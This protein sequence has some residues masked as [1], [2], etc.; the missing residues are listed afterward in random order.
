V[1]KSLLLLLDFTLVQLVMI[2]Y[3]WM[4]TLDL[5]ALESAMNISSGKQ[6]RAWTGQQSLR[7]KSDR[8]CLGHLA[9][10]AF[11]STK[12]AKLPMN[13]INNNK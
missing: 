3:W 13:L 10:S 9:T 1:M 4:T 5:I 2:S 8:T 11:K 12:P 6:S 7:P